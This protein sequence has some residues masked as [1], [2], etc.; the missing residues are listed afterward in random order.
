MAVFWSY[1][2]STI[3]KTN[4]K[5]KVNDAHVARRGLCSLIFGWLGSREP[6][7]TN[8]I[9]TLSAF[10]VSISEVLKI[11]LIINISIILKVAPDT[12]QGL[13]K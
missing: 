3:S 6:H 12:Y 10:F 1:E 11:K 8:R 9:G 2:I 7:K 13:K 5:Y 4:Q